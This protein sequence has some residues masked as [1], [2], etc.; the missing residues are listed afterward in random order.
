MTTRVMA[1]TQTASPTLYM[2]N[3]A[4][5]DVLEQPTAQKTELHK[6]IWTHSPEH[7]VH[8]MELLHQQK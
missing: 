5:D 8:L 7:V 1:S 2:A 4:V 3:K 6:V